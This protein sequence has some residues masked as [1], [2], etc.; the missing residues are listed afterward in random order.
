[1]AKRTSKDTPRRPK[2]DGISQDSLYG[3]W[4]LKQIFWEIAHKCNRELCHEQESIKS[5]HYIPLYVTIK[6][7]VYIS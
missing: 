6:M 1:M 5:A 7:L 3:K 2:F 4:V